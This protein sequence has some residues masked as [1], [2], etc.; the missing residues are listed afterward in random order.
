MI[1]RL[2]QILSHLKEARHKMYGHCSG[3]LIGAFSHETDL[4]AAPPSIEILE[5]ISVLWTK[6][7]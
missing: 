5:V 7:A 1:V 3:Y 6:R 4:S 2:V